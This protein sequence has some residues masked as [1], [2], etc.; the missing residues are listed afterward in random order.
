MVCIL[1]LSLL[2]GCNVT[3]LI[4]QGEELY[5]G[6]E[7]KIV[8]QGEVQNTRSL[9]KELEDV[10]RPKPNSSIF[11]W[12]PRIWVYYKMGKTKDK[13]FK[14]WVK[15]K[16]GEKPVLLEDANPEKTV[17]VMMNRMENK[18]HFHSLAS[19]DIE[20]KDKKARVLYIAKAKPQYI[21]QKIEAPKGEDSLSSHIRRNMDK[22][23]L[24]SGDPYDLDVL[25]QERSRLDAVLKNEGFY[26]FNPDFLLF[27]ADSTVGNRRINLSLEIKKDAPPM[28][29]RPYKL[30]DIFVF[31]NYSLTRDSASAN[32]Y[33]V[34]ENGYYFVNDEEII[35]TRPVAKSILLEQN[36]TYSRNDHNQTLA[37]LM[38]MGIFKFVDIKLQAA[39]PPDTLDKLDALIYLTPLKKKSLRVEVQGVSKSNS[40]TGPELRASF[41]N[42]SSF[43]GAELLILN[44][45]GSFESQFGRASSGVNSYE[46]G[47][48]SQLVFPS[49]LSPFR[50]KKTS[51]AYVPKT[52]FEAGFR[53][54]NRVRFFSVNSFNFTYGYRWKEITTKE[55][56]L[57][58]V[59][60]N[61]SHLS[62]ST[63]AFE[64]VL[65]RNAFLRKSFRDQFIIGSNY[66]F[67]YNNQ[68][69][70]EKTH[71]LYF[72]GVLDF[73][74]NLLRL[75]KSTGGG[76]PNEDG[77]YLLFGVPFSQYSRFITD[78]RYAFRINQEA[79]IAT[80]LIVG[81][82]LPYGNS[83]VMPYL[84]Q[85]F[86][87]GSNSIRAFQP[88]SL[89][90][91]NYVTPDTSR[92]RAFSD[93]S[94]DI[95]IEGN[96]E[97]RFKIISI[98]K[99]AL[100][101][102]AGN[103]WL[104]N[105]NPQLG[106]GEFR[107]DFL[108]EVAVGTGFG[109]R[110]DITFLV[111]RFDLGFPLRK[112][113]VEGSNKWVINGIKPGSSAWRKDNLVLNVAIGYPF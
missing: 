51:N 60:I 9:K 26:Y 98:V 36:K 108:R 67:T 112:P 38:G 83:E 21:F 73:S 16:I 20:R 95:K 77:S 3:K 35:K 110:F 11:G 100:F 111:L 47:A 79:K 58:P 86:V 2:A 61:L 40:Y 84:K 43:R 33:G 10:V 44:L 54:L 7:V 90:P 113:F 72:N 17:L 71:Q 12:R 97:Y 5:T 19:F 52:K 82:G 64:E 68:L 42:R 50:L 105:P 48:T 109:V 76:R 18:G 66:S 1:M 96:A 45:N 41:R 37:R 81:A 8:P 13:G 23:L 24:R 102:D 57:N 78:S 31:T 49:F 53:F 25:K 99:G 59:A 29:I 55:H 65:N 27:K 15:N 34:K 56:E 101:V 32:A 14:H 87:G 94:G 74:G 28:A 69:L 75:L 93:Q 22:T 6:A 89:G 70:Q 88:R 63:P 91:G 30:N 92:T 107:R 103:I 62:R 39:Q 104:V 46:L 4:P 85:F 80:R 106:G